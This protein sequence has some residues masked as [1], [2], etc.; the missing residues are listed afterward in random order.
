MCCSPSPFLTLLFAPLCFCSFFL[1]LLLLVAPIFSSFPVLPFSAFLHLFCFPSILFSKPA[2]FATFRPKLDLATPRASLYKNVTLNRKEAEKL[3]EISKIVTV[4][5]KEKYLST[6]D[7]DLQK[8]ERK[9]KVRKFYSF[10][11]I[12]LLCSSSA[13]SSSTY[14]AN[15]DDA[16]CK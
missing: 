14:C 16:C 9:E 8:E 7:D 11:T 5:G 13:R 3:I 6:A 15:E 12:Q 4:G 1:P 2:R 10:C